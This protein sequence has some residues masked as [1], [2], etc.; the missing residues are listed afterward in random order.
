MSSVFTFL[1]FNVFSLYISRLQCLFSLY[2]KTSMSFVFIFPRLQSFLSL[3]FK[4]SIFF[5]FT[6]QDFN[7]SYFCYARLQRLLI[8]TS[9]TSV[10]ISICSFFFTCF[11]SLV[12]TTCRSDNMVTRMK[13]VSLSLL[14]FSFPIK[15]K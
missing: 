2:F 3:H 13:L 12:F 7:V 11:T 5:V 8:N 10:P 1:D 4:T 6:F 9:D 15:D 14:T